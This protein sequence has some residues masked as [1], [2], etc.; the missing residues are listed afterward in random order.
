MQGNSPYQGLAARAYWRTGLAETPYPPAGIYQPKW[1][2]AKTDRIVTAGSCFAQHVGRALRRNG[3]NVLDGEPAPDRIPADQVSRYGYGLYSARY[4]NIYTA[5]QLRQLLEEAWDIAPD[6]DAIWHKDGRCYDALRPNIEP[7]GFPDEATLRQARLLHLAKVREVFSQADVFVFTLGLTEAW[8][9]KPTGQVYPTAPGTIAGSFDEAL[10]GFVNFRLAE[11]RADLLAALAR[12]KALNP[13][14]RVLLTVSP[15][16]LTATASGDHVLPATSYSKSVLRACAGEL[17]ADF[18]EIDYFPSYEIVTSTKAGASYFEPNL[19]SV[20]DEGVARVMAVFT[21]AHL[22]DGSSDA[23]P[24]PEPESESES[25]SEAGD[26]N[27]EDRKDRRAQRQERRERRR[28]G[29]EA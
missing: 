10:H 25:E 6:F 9:H 16:P 28:A 22:E 14:L 5:R 4:G 13:G 11:V 17:A 21:R 19:R 2:L 12:L 23:G 18:P 24:A 15:V 27:R 1:R 7:D 26:Q 3:F 29:K 8:M 20:T